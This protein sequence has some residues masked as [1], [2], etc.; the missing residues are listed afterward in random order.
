M[1][2]IKKPFLNNR[3]LIPPCL[4]YVNFHRRRLMTGRSARDICDDCVQTTLGRDLE[5]SW[6][7]VWRSWVRADRVGP[8]SP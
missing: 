3:L 8:V 5:S 6:R 2:R 4:Q 7:G 1:L